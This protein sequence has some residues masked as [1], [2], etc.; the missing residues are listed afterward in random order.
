MVC[1]LNVRTSYTSRTCILEQ[2]D[3]NTACFEHVPCA[4]CHFLPLS[5][6]LP[7]SLYLKIS[8]ARYK[9]TPTQHTVYTSKTLVLN[10]IIEQ[11]QNMFSP[12][13]IHKF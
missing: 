13:D 10:W 3:K 2:L 9:Y 6:S 1:R 11:V 8:M 7:L 5:L 4:L 12:A